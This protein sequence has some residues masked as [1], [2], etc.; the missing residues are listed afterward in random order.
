MISAITY[1]VV[2]VLLA[3]QFV[4]GLPELLAKKDPTCGPTVAT[5]SH[6]TTITVESILTIPHACY[7]HTVTTKHHGSGCPDV[8]TCGPH[9]DCIMLSTETVTLP[10]NDLCCPTTPTVAVQGPCP[11]CQKGCLTNTVTEYLTG[12]PASLAK[13]EAAITPCTKVIFMSETMVLG[14]TKTVHPLTS[15]STVYVPCGG[16]QLMTS[17]IGGIGPEISFS[18][19]ITDPST[20]TSTAWVCM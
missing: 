16:C 12:D 6:V 3:G 18:A 4:A 13:K 19:T 20:A 2:L 7:T 8:S 1:S 15:T 11:T 10:A 9:A 17:N 14:P 5:V